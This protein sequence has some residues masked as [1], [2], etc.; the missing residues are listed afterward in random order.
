M[1]ASKKILVPLDFSE[2]S[3]AAER[4]AEE[5]AKVT[6]AELMFV[7]VIDETP[8]L[9]VDGAGYLPVSAVMEYEAASK[10]MLEEHAQRAAK[11]GVPVRFRT[12]H[13]RAERAIVAAADQDRADLIVMGTH[14]RTGIR[15]ALLGSVAERVT[16]LS[17][18]P[19]M[20]VRAQAVQP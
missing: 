14:G 9:L 7:N 10:Q 5:L 12:L 19:V 8:F 18:V 17:K 15:R 11:G 16:R 4:C 3:T 20:T 1:P 13:G 2:G 6:G